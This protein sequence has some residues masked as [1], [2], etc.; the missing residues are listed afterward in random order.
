MCCFFMLFQNERELFLVRVDQPDNTL[1][2][3]INRNDRDSDNENQTPVHDIQTVALEDVAAEIGEQHLHHCN[4][5]HELKEILVAGNV[6]EKI[7][8]LGTCVKRIEHGDEDKESKIGCPV[9]L[10]EIT[11]FV[12]PVFACDKENKADQHGITG[13]DK[14]G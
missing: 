7:D 10:G 6:I 11:P 5:R 14:N 1:S 2:D 8:F 4:Q 3:Y 13:A 12:H 9:N